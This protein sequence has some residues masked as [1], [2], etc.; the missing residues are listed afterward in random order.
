MGDS[1]ISGNPPTAADVVRIE[2]GRLAEHWDE[3]TREQSKSALPMFKA[4]F[5]S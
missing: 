1:P 5:P 4:K 3:A 2:D